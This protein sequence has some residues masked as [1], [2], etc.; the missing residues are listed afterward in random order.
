MITKPSQVAP[1]CLMTIGAVAKQCAVSIR[2]VRRWIKDGKLVA[3]QLGRQWR[4]SGDDLRA[5]LNARRG[6]NLHV[7]DDR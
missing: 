3:H 7:R 4:V 5:F 1:D 6:A 2:T